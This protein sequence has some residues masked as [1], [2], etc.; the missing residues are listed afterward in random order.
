MDLAQKK[1]NKN[2]WEAIEVPSSSNE[3][4]ILKLIVEG[5]DNVNVKKNNALS[6]LTFMKIN[7][8]I[9]IYHHYFYDIYFKKI[10]DKLI[11]KYSFPP[12]SKPKSN[13][14]KLKKADI[15]RIEN[16]NRKLDSI[17]DTIYEFVLLGLI[18]KSPG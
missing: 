1:L 13:K 18:T 16:S 7:K 14:I 4:E 17:K 8:N 11:K 15:I 6:I 10:I 12:Y 9:D 2:E 3:L 5:Y